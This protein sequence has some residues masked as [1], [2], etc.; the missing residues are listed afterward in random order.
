MVDVEV[1]FLADAEVA[2]LTDAGMASLTD[3][4]EVASLVD[5]ASVNTDGVAFWKEG[6]VP[7]DSVCDYDDYFYDAC[8]DENPDYFDY[9][10]PE[11]FDSYPDVYG[12]IEPDDY[13]LCH[14]LHGPG[15]CGVYCVARGE[16]G[17]PPYWSGDVACIRD[18]FTLDRVP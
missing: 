4:V 9:D 17:G 7:N 8:Y 6:D 5:S 16:A 14:D 11:D 12:F 10:H 2:S 15:D 13:E 3:I 1:A 18:V